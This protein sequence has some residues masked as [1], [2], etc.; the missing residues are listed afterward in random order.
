MTEDDIRVSYRQA[1]N[2]KEQI[3]ILSQLNGCSE[4]DI[5][6]VLQGEKPQG[7]YGQLIR[8]SGKRYVE[9][10]DENIEILRKYVVSDMTYD[11]IAKTLKLS[12][13]NLRSAISRFG[14]GRY[15]KR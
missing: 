2:P 14:M 3:A 7:A 4:A 1:R 6:R 15:Q 13:K 12:V 10:N 8:K 9:W 5:E 11:E